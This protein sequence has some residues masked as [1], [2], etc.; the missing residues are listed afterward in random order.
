VDG[1][2]FVWNVDHPLFVWVGRARQFYV[3]SR[4]F[5][6]SRF[7][8]TPASA[9]GFSGFHIDPLAGGTLFALAIT[10]YL[11]GCELMYSD[12]RFAIDPHT[13][14]A[15]REI[16]PCGARA[17]TR[18][19]LWQRANVDPLL[20]KPPTDSR[21]KVFIIVFIAA[22]HALV[23][24]DQVAAGVGAGPDFELAH[25]LFL[26]LRVQIRVHDLGV[27]LL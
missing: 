19:Y 14:S 12:W 11:L 10:K 17:S 1:T 22:T 18:L 26:G 4:G 3:S 25:G 9:F 5:G 21:G 20:V 23:L 7:R 24:L 13:W 6:F 16:A 15:V 8:T 27:H 2:V